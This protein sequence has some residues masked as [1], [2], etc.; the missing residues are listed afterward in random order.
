[1]VPKLVQLREEHMWAHEQDRFKF[2]PRENDFIRSSDA[3]NVCRAVTNDEIAGVHHAQIDVQCWP[4]L[5]AD[6]GPPIR[7]LV[8]GRERPLIAR[9]AGRFAFRAVSVQAANFWFF[10]RIE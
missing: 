1:M 4:K 8:V 2:R 6:S 3:V 10:P 9:T 7:A 5:L